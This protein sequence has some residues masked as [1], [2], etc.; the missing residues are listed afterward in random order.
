MRGYCS[1]LKEERFRL[2]LLSPIFRYM[3]K[4]F[5]DNGSK[6][7]KQVTQRGGRCPSMEIFKVWLGRA[8]SNIMSQQVS[9]FIAGE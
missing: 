1:K 3:K 2:Y 9:L 4:V 7:L 8:L 5:S 6:A